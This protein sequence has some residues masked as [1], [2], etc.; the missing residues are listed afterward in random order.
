[1]DTLFYLQQ[2]SITAFKNFPAAFSHTFRSLE[3]PHPL[4]TWLKWK[5]QL[6]GQPELSDKPT[7]TCT[8]L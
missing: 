7:F 5:H 6:I 8:P 3:A 1:M 2:F 4:F